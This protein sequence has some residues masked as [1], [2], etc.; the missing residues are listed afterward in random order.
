MCHM[1]ADTPEELQE[2][3]DKLGIPRNYVQYKGTYREHYDIC[4]TKRRLAIKL[5]AKEVTMWDTGRMMLRK[6]EP[7][8]ERRS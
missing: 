8:N 7:K 6:K 2:M 1:F 3:V 4:L 5:G